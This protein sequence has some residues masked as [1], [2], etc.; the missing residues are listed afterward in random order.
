MKKI[1]LLA[2]LLLYC[3][4]L[5]YGVEITG[6][7]EMSNNQKTQVIGLA[8]SQSTEAADPENKQLTKLTEPEDSEPVSEEAREI[9]DEVLAQIS[10]GRGFSELIFPAHMVWLNGAPGAGKGTN[11][12]TVMRILE[13]STKPVE[14]SSL[15]TSPEAQELKAS[16]RLVDD[17]TVIKLVFETLLRPENAGGIII[18]GFPRTRIQAECLKLL[19]KKI[20][21]C[22]Q[23]KWSR[24]TLVN[25]MISQET[26]IERQLSRGRDSLEHNKIVESSNIGTLVPVRDTDLSEDAAN[27]RY[28]TYLDETRESLSILKGVMEYDEIDAEGSLEEVRDRIYKVFS[29]NP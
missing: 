12:A 17:K 26:S 22:E 15:L 1:F 27:F 29:A 9:F 11:T 20:H 5:A 16:G 7:D 18:D 3:I 21:T 10:G 19:V 25:F 23:S 28:Q 6:E 2:C 24:F 14:V 13:I 8:N 4:P